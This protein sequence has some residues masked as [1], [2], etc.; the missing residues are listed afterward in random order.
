MTC[1]QEYAGYHEGDEHDYVSEHPAGRTW[2]LRLRC[3]KAA[4]GYGS[5]HVIVAVLLDGRPYEGEAAVRMIAR[6][7]RLPT[8]QGYG[9]RAYET[10]VNELDGERVDA[11]EFGS[12]PAAFLWRDLVRLRGLWSTGV[13][14]DALHSDPYQRRERRPEYERM[15][16]VARLLAL[17]TERPID[18]LLADVDAEAD[19][20]RFGPK[21]T[22]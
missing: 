6:S 21:V 14:A 22:A 18:A 2:T 13:S 12:D 15:M 9:V 20:R 7:E 11:L 19:T 10:R 4:E 5:D 17:L 1:G 8:P 16:T 3:T